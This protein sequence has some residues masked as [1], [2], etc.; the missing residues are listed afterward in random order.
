MTLQGGG[1]N[2]VVGGTNSIY[3]NIVAGTTFFTFHTQDDNAVFGLGFA[4][5]EP[6]AR[7]DGNYQYT[8][9]RTPIDFVRYTAGAPATPTAAFTFPDQ[10]FNRQQLTLGATVP[11]DQNI[12]VRGFYMYD[13]VND[14][15]WHYDGLADPRISGATGLGFQL[16]R[17][18]SA[19]FK[20]QTLGL[21]LQY[22]M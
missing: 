2:A 3:G 4:H 12:A 21:M 14:A 11:V 7:F 6:W 9:T 22:K 10:V 13:R 5:A 17:N 19:S 8:H 15:D 16:D 1:C 18:P 20:A